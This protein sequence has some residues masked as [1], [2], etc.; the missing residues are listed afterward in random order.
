MTNA[1]TSLNIMSKKKP[2]T[3]HEIESKTDYFFEKSDTDRDNKIT[4]KE[5]KSYVKQDPEI[6]SILFS[7]DIAKKEDLGTNQG[8]GD[9]PEHDSDLEAELN[10]PELE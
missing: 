5:F 4:L 3:I 10:P 8:S 9:I 7:H 6:L 2:P 1:L